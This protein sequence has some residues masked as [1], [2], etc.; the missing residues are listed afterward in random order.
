MAM[1]GSKPVE[2]QQ[3]NKGNRQNQRL[4]CDTDCN[5]G[6]DNNDNGDQHDYAQV[7]D[8]SYQES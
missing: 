5:E 4:I 3:A 1:H 8:S 6:P 7:L 2:H